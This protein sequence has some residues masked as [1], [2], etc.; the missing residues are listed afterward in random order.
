MA[1]VRGVEENPD[2][3]KD[4]VYKVKGII[5]LED[6]IEEILGA[7]IVDETDV[8]IDVDNHVKVDRN[9]F[10]WARLRLLDSRAVDKVR[11]R[12]GSEERHGAS[13]ARGP[14]ES[15]AGAGSE[16]PPPPSVP[17]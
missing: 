5:T 14:A 17:P 1:L 8:F 16:P 12:G 3:D 10:D 7:E 9:T 15:L 13:H 6:I 4:P 2:E 11:A